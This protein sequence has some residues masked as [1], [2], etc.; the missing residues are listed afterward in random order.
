M[1][2][3]FI[4]GKVGTTGLALE[5]R[6]KTRRDIKILSLPE[7]ERKD[8]AAR[9][10]AMEQAHIT[11]LCLPDE[12]AR[13]AVALAEGTNTTVI[14][15][16]T[17]HRTQ[18]GWA[19]GFPELGAAFRRNIALGKRIAVPGCHASGFVALVKPLVEAGFLAKGAQLHCFSLTGYTG[20]GK[21]MIADYEH[22]RVP[23]DLLSAPRQYALVQTHKH[24]PEMCAATGLLNAP[25][26]C[27][28]VAD[29]D[30]GM[31]VTVTLHQSQ[32]QNT[33][34]NTIQRCYHEFYADAKLITCTNDNENGFLSAN[35]MRMKDSM[36]LSV[37]GNDDRVLLVARFDNLGKGASGAAVQCMNI[38]LGLDEATGLSI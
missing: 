7:T 9:K 5:E 11:F 15:A 14:D 24:L 6:L 29:F 10:Q 38:A 21:G 23:Q 8:P 31:E 32:V 16:S 1:T 36:A 25:V 20:G 3:V 4:D 12:P 17:A 27:P 33:N 2:R 19:Y 13:Q 37:Y 22:E 18:P 26:F 35:K 28:V 34:M 30:R